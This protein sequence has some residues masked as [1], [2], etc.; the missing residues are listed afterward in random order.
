M[1]MKYLA[2]A[3]AVA[4][5]A[6]AFALGAPS[7]GTVYNEPLKDF[8]ESLGS[9]WVSVLSPGTY[10]GHWSSANDV[11]SI[12]GRSSITFT[13]ISS[14]V[15]NWTLNVVSTPT[16]VSANGVETFQDYFSIFL[17][18]VPF[19]PNLKIGSGTGY[20]VHQTASIA[21]VPGPEAGTGLA[22]VAIACVSALAYR[23]KRRA[24]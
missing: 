6:P 9:G 20:E 1:K 2:F 16:S 24:A 10:R 15:Y 12:G 19:G 3:L 14:T 8:F 4:F 23:L 11:F 17:N 13:G 18:K 21:A 5:S 22:A 7:T